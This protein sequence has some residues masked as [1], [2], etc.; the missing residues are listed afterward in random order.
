MGVITSTTCHRK[1]FECLIPRERDR[2]GEIMK[3]KERYKK[4]PTYRANAP[5]R[6]KET[7]SRSDKRMDR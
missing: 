7:K 1:I 2:E 3:Q 5:G 4:R 6:R